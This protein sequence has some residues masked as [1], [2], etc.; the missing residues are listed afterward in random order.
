MAPAAGTPTPSG[1]PYAT[2]EPYLIKAADD[3]YVS[4]SDD[5]IARSKVLQRGLSASEPLPLP[6]LAVT[7]RAF[8]DG[9]VDESTTVDELI[10]VVKVCAKPV[11]HIFSR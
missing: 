11:E 2:S 8:N 3:Q 4:V 1:E 5:A 10:D 9:K 7:V 6:F